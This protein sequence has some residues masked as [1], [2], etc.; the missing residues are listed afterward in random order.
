MC[1]LKYILQKYVHRKIHCILNVLINT[2]KCK[3]WYISYIFLDKSNLIFVVNTFLNIM[4][5][6]HIKIFQSKVSLF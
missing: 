5:N 3:N 1:I 6:R 2:H 4:E